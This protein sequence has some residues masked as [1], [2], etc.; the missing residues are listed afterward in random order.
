MSEKYTLTASLGAK[1]LQVEIPYNGP[2]YEAIES[3]RAYIRGWTR[4]EPSGPWALGRI[5]LRDESGE[6]DCVLQHSTE[7]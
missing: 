4:V 3:V 6:L 2:A 7:P 1:V 5:E